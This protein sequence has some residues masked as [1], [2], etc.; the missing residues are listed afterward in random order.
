MVPHFVSQLGAQGSFFAHI[1]GLAG[2]KEENRRRSKASADGAS[3]K[4]SGCSKGRSLHKSHRG[5][6]GSVAQIKK[7]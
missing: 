6:A 2:N 5:C 4:L 1:L 7:S 3:W